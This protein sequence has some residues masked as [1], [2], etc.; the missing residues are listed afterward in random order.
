MSNTAIHPLRVKLTIMTDDDHLRERLEKQL[1]GVD[2]I[3]SAAIARYL[4]CA[5]LYYATVRYG[6][7][8]SRNNQRG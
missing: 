7:P 3:K 4:R 1:G 5:A 8:P 6:A 2:S